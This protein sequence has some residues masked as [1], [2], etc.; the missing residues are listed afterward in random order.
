MRLNL[1]QQAQLH[2]GV[3]STSRMQGIAQRSRN[4]T[5]NGSDMKY[6]YMMLVKKQYGKGEAFFGTEF[7]ST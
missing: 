3:A 2:W 6:E 4:A 5:S 1:A 7:R